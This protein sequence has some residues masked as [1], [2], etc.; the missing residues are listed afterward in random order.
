MDWP[1]H[2]SERCLKEYTLGRR[3]VTC[4][5]AKDHEGQ[6]RAHEGHMEYG[7]VLATWGDSEINYANP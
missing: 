6:H 5:R 4:S 1:H 2:L 7:A 3:T